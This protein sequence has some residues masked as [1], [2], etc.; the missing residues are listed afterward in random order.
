MTTRTDITGER[1]LELITWDWQ[2][3]EQ[4]RQMLIPT[5]PPGKAL[6]KYQSIASRNKG[7]GNRPQLTEDEQIASG[8]RNIVNA[9]INSQIDSGRAEY[10][11]TRTHIRLAERRIVNKEGCC[12]TCYRPFQEATTVSPRPT[13]QATPRSKVVYPSF[14]SWEKNSQ[15]TGAM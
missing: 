3:L 12:P 14:P 1:F 11:E 6:R 2:D 4:I 13:S 5:V 7:T 15:Q 9:R 8:A 10:D